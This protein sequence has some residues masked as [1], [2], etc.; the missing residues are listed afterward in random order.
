MFNFN[1][2]QKQ[3]YP[4]L[5]FCYHPFISIF[6]DLLGAC[7][8]VKMDKMMTKVRKFKREKT[9]R[10]KKKKRKEEI[11]KE[12]ERTDISVQHHNSENSIKI[13]KRKANQYSATKL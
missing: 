4:K 12:L 5:Q 1:K 6:N 7:M 9:K 2:K 10:K 3:F 13:I 11:R 8:L